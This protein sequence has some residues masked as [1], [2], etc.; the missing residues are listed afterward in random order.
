MNII[1]PKDESVGY[2]VLDLRDA[3]EGAEMRFDNGEN[4]LPECVLVIP[5]KY[6]TVKENGEYSFKLLNKYFKEMV[7]K[8]C[9][10]DIKFALTKLVNT[11]LSLKKDI[12]VIIMEKGES[13]IIVAAPLWENSVQLIEV[14][15]K[16][17]II[18][19]GETEKFID[20]TDAGCC[21]Y[22]DLLDIVP[23]C[24]MGEDVEQLIANHSSNNKS[25][26][27]NKEKSMDLGMEI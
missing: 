8:D 14:V 4:S 9:C 13:S 26:K 11:E 17:P 7:R 6:L 25:A 19:L 5:K 22:A 1:I 12:N 3:L 23:D 15:I 24:R 16:N 2:F 20:V 21:P 18:E 10:A 27:K